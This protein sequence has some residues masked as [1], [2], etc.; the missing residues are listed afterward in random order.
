MRGITPLIV[1]WTYIAQIR[2]P[3]HRAV[4][5]VHR[6]TL[7]AVHYTDHEKYSA[8]RDNTVIS[9]RQIEHLV[10]LT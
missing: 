8:S 5:A 3:G 1:Y 2:M 4:G 7:L 10:V 6:L 9:S